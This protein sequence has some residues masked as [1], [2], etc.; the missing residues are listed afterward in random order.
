MQAKLGQLD[1]NFR[2]TTT[3]HI[4]TIY[5]TVAEKSPGIVNQENLSDSLHLPTSLQLKM[6]QARHLE[7]FSTGCLQN[8]ETEIIV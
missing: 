5:V 2:E 4:W 7:I 1:I 8:T 6:L 3:A